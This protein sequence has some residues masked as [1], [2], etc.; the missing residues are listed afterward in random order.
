MCPEKLA[1]HI[2]LNVSR[3]TTYAKLRE[4]VHLFIQAQPDSETKPNPDAMEVDHLQQAAN[5]LA[6]LGKGGKGFGK[7]KGKYG[8]GGFGSP[9]QSFNPYKGGYNNLSLI[10]I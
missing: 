2:R 1:G 4:E 3:L 9:F 5:Q 10:H 8:K 6:A 7:G